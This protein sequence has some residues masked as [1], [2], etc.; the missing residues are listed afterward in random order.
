MIKIPVE[1]VFPIVDIFYDETY[2]VR[3]EANNII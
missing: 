2:G 3:K 1:E